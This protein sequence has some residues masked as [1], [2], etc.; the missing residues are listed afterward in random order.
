MLADITSMPRAFCTV[1][2]YQLCSAA[3]ATSGDAVEGGGGGVQRY[4]MYSDFDK[5]FTGNSLFAIEFRDVVHL[6]IFELIMKLPNFQNPVDSVF[7]VPFISIFLNIIFKEQLIND[8][9]PGVA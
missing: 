6:P 4:L 1:G 8:L 3:I 5:T 9:A 7:E 2:R